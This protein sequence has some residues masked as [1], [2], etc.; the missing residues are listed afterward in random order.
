MCIRDRFI[1]VEN[2][3]E[4]I[5]KDDIV[6]EVSEITNVVETLKNGKSP[7]MEGIYPEL[8]KYAPE[9]LHVI[10][11]KLF[12][13]CMNGEKPP[14]EWT[15][16]YIT[17]IHKKGAK[18]DPKNYRGIAVI[19]TLGRVYTK[20]I[21]SR[22]ENEIKDKQPEEQAG[23]RTGRS[24]IDN[25]FTIKIA[26]EKRVQRNREL[27]IAMIDLEKAYDSVPVSQLWKALKSL[28][29]SNMLIPVSYTHLDVYKRQVFLL[30]P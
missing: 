10:L 8:V 28:E 15:T 14:M 6:I 11:A 5:E 22:L 2:P 3:E 4:T 1:E 18:N 17:P 21:K 19:C 29:V 25:I 23:F 9:E 13:R 12:E 7:G 30:I 16:S 27:H 26:C 20:I 24:T